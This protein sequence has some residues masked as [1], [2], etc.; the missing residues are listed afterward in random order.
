MMVFKF[1]LSM[2]FWLRIMIFRRKKFLK[3]IVLDTLVTIFWKGKCVVRG[4]WKRKGGYI[5]TLCND[6][7]TVINPM[8]YTLVS[9][10][11]AC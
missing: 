10:Q 7:V 3:F 5:G 4:S 6:W 8:S 1:D 9:L 2:L 11:Y